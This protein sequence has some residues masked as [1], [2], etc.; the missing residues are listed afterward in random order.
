MPR[1]PRRD[2][3]AIPRDD[4]EQDI[5]I[6]LGVSADMLSGRQVN[7]V[8]VQLAAGLGELPHRAWR[9]R[10][11]RCESPDVAQDAWHAGR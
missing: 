3:N 7:H 6:R 9:A 8:R 1:L 2:E 11:G 5:E 10:R 4:Q